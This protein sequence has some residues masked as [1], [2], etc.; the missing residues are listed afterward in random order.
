[1]KT[2]LLIKRLF[3]IFQDEK[4]NIRIRTYNSFKEI[5]CEKYYQTKNIYENNY[6]KF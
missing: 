3:I 4:Y 5:I 6:S 1:M 2:Q